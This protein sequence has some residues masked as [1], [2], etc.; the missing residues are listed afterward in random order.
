[1]LIS[2]L[3]A[4]R[5]VTPGAALERTVEH[6]AHQKARTVQSPQRKVHEWVPGLPKLTRGGSVL[7]SATDK[8]LRSRG[9]DSG[10][11]DEKPTL[12][13]TGPG[14]SMYCTYYYV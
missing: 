4:F 13:G 11:P 5:Q 6:C 2:P 14:R 9:Y 3:G 8:D 1:M 12:P 7:F 10:I